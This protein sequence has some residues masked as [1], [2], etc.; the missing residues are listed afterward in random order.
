M[1]M[2]PTRRISLLVLTV[3]ALA[4]V[5]WLLPLSSWLPVGS[6]PKAASLADA[7]GRLGALAPVAAVG[8]SATLLV[9]L[10][11]RTPVSLACG[12]L[13]GAWLGAVCALAATMTAATITFVLGRW[14]GRD[15]MA[16]R[17][18][19]HWFTVERWIA[20]EGVL[21]V[22][23]VRAMP[24]GPYGLAGYAYGSSGVRIRD[25]LLGTLIAG[26]PSAIS[27]AMLGAAVASPGRLDPLALAPL[28]VGL[29]LS[30]AVIVRA[31]RRLTRHEAAPTATADV[32]HF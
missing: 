14:L 31:R 28:G 16:R 13:F 22:A 24:T 7:V 6:L 26:T 4:A 1:R 27:Y 29:L 20:R 25:Y 19:R 11:P 21:A 15:F 9:A 3:G 17:T 8:V 30:T 10:V 2:S 23:A 18:G 5:A 12:L 32:P